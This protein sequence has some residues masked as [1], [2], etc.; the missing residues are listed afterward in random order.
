M[1]KLLALALIIVSPKAEVSKQEI[2]KPAQAGSYAQSDKR[3]TKE[4]PLYVDTHPILSDS[5]A[6]E[7]KR[8]EDEHEHTD[9]WIVRL[10]LAIAFCS[11]AQVYVYWRQKNIMQD[12][13][14]SINTQATHMA[15]QLAFQQESMRPRLSVS[16]FDGQPF[17]DA[18]NGK[19]VI[20]NTKI[21]NTGNITAYG[22]IVETWME[23][24][25]GVP[26]Y[27]LSARAT[28]KKAAPINVFPG[29]PMGFMLPFARKL[30]TEERR[31]MQKAQGTVC[32]RM[33]INYIS[34]GEE[35]H[36][37]EGYVMRPDAMDTMAQYA[38]AT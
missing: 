24:V 35:V 27:S 12:T 33:R 22:V 26:P 10:T 14:S 17:A 31:G 11:V 19:F 21:S 37:D 3:G 18:L 2:A 1:L 29:N 13:L 23:F 4:S 7:E 16:S 30:T 38:S 8:R 25:Y 20:V 5:D 28:Y 34:F 6:A 15:S 32:F 9:R 36:T